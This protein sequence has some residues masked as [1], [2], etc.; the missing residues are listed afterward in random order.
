MFMGKPIA[1]N[2]RIP[3]PV[4]DLKK[5]SP[6]TAGSPL[7]LLSGLG[8]MVRV[9]G[10]RAVE[11]LPKSPSVFGLEG[12]GAEAQGRWPEG[13][14]P[15]AVSGV[16]ILA[17]LFFALPQCRLKRF[18]F[19]NSSLEGCFAIIYVSSLFLWDW[20]LRRLDDN[21]WNWR[22]WP[23][24]TE[25]KRNQPVMSRTIN[26]L[27]CELFESSL[28]CARDSELGVIFWKRWLGWVSCHDYSLQSLE[29]RSAF[30]DIPLLL[31]CVWNKCI[32]PPTNVPCHRGRIGISWEKRMSNRELETPKDK[33]SN[34]RFLM[35][36]HLLWSKEKRLEM[37]FES[38]VNFYYWE[39]S[40]DHFSFFPYLES[41]WMSAIKNKRNWASLPDL[42]WI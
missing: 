23:Q 11:Q 8:E 13:P 27:V 36:G 9:L 32:T 20:V 17:R 4:K 22:N 16:E 7:S 31:L 1:K 39:W 15:P 41:A 35:I 42:F 12:G 6:S 18:G 5:H 29:V 10:V 2:G 34:S 33:T 37:F 28:F 40:L 38:F 30:V 25:S 19:W 3:L 14:P 21:G 26:V 24:L